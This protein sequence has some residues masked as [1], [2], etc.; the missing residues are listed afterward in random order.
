MSM[1]R[2]TQQRSDRRQPQVHQKFVTVQMTQH[3]SISSKPQHDEDEE[4]KGIFS[5]KNA[6]N[7]DKNNNKN[8]QTLYTRVEINVMRKTQNKAAKT[9]I[10][11]KSR[12]GSKDGRLE[13]CGSG[14]D[15]RVEKAG[16]H[17]SQMNETRHELLCSIRTVT[18]Y[19]N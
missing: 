1:R 19:A 11:T 10:L 14:G 9:R 16:G 6:A 8:C 4:K 7:N 13:A 2:V 12:M 17:N 18:L 15:G 5:R 3:F